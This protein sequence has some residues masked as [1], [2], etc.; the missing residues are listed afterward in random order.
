MRFKAEDLG[1]N[2]NNPGNMQIDGGGFDGEIGRTRDD[3]AI[4]DSMQSC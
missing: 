4:F 3:F 1:E 2:I